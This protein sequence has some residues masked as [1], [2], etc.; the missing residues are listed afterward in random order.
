MIVSGTAGFLTAALGGGLSGFFVLPAMRKIKTGVS[1]KFLPDRK[2]LKEN[3]RS[4]GAAITALTGFLVGLLVAAAVSMLSGESGGI[5]LFVPCAVLCIALTACGFIDDYLTDLKGFSVGLKTPLRI[6]FTA[7]SGLLFS[8]LYLLMGG[9]SLVAIPFLKGA[10]RTGAFFC[11]IMT[12]ATAVFCEGMRLSGNGEGTDS[13]QGF[14]SLVFLVAASA[15]S[16][17]STAFIFSLTASGAVFGLLGWSFPPPL[18]KSGT[19]GKY[20]VSGILISSCML[21]AQKGNLFFVFAL[22]VLMLLAF[23]ADR[24]VYKLTGKHIFLKLPAD[25]H[26][27]LCG[28]SEKK[29]LIFYFGAAALFSALCLVSEIF[30]N[31]Y[32]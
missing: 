17:N 4:T 10:I 32:L 11:P 25:E 9:D 14:A 2:K 23:P 18:M 1:S 8:F 3:V 26:L 20:L 5:A 24:A 15:V 21:S 6:L 13:V 7:F 22:P 31:Y 19:S 29:T 27:K 12:A 28:F 16:G 30:K